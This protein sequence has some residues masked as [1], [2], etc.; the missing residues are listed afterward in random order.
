MSHPSD[1]IEEQHLARTLGYE[2]L[3]SLVQRLAYD[4]RADS[5]LEESPDGLIA[6]YTFLVGA[7]RR[8]LWVLPDVVKGH[9]RAVRE[10]KRRLLKAHEDLIRR[11]LTLLLTTDAT[12]VT[13]QSE[14]VLW[15]HCGGKTTTIGG[16]HDEG[17]VA[18]S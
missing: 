12:E 3:R 1:P 2:L 4:I 14:E 6:L 10:R 8:R 7:E 16:E 11:A 15:L 13:I 17:E 18:G 5:R 9:G